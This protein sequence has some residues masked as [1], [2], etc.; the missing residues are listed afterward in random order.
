MHG[1]DHTEDEDKPW[2]ACPP[3]SGNCGF[4]SDR[5]STSIVSRMKT[6]SFAMGVGVVLNPLHTN[7]LCGYGGDGGTRGVTCNPP[8]ITEQCIPGCLH[9]PW[10]GEWCDP[11]KDLDE[12][13]YTNP[14]KD[15]GATAWC[16]GK[17]WRPSDFGDLLARDHFSD[18]Y[19]EVVVD[20][21]Y[22]N[23]QLPH[24]I[25]AMISTPNDIPYRNHY[26]RFL[27]EYKLTPA[28]VPLLNF[29]PSHPEHPFVVDVASAT[30]YV[31]GQLRAEGGR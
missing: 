3:Y 21:H 10:R 19:N 14:L 9:S 20:A 29:D 31:S 8:G 15:V 28:D 16:D 30:S 1:I 24:S 27:D 7:I 12:K 6:V 22:W 11:S 23:E 18:H 5:M 26:F 25:W 4:L 2:R 17:P 13:D